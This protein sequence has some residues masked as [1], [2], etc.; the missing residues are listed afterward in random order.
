VGWRSVAFLTVI[1]S[2]VF[3]RH[4][5][6]YATAPVIATNGR[7]KAATM[8]LVLT[9]NLGGACKKEKKCSKKNVDEKE[10]KKKR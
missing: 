10:K 5:R 7:H 4:R 8:T 6:H 2:I 9:S 1:R 3:R